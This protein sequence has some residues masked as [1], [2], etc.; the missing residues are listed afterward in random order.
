MN[1]FCGVLLG[2]I[3]QSLQCSSI[4]L[5]LQ[6]ELNKRLQ[7]DVRSRPTLLR[8]ELGSSELLK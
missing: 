1:T 4:M 6:R 8:T 3:S 2:G 7:R 5:R